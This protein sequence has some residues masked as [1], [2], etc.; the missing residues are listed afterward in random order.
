MLGCKFTL[1]ELEDRIDELEEKFDEMRTNTLES[2]EMKRV[3]V[4]DVVYELT[5][6]KAREKAEHEVILDKKKLN[7]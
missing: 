2:L 7:F 6:L 4:R 1:A 5:T 3:N